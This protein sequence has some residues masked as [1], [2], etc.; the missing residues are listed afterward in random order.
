[1]SK[2]EKCECDVAAAYLAEKDQSLCKFWG[3]DCGTGMR[4]EI[5]LL[6]YI[7]MQD[8]YKDHKTY[9]VALAPG[10]SGT[11]PNI[12]SEVE[13]TFYACDSYVVNMK[14]LLNGVVVF[15]NFLLRPLMLKEDWEFAHLDDE[16]DKQGLQAGTLK[17]RLNDYT[18]PPA[19]T[20]CIKGMNIHSVFKVHSTDP[21]RMSPLLPG[22]VA[23]FK[24]SFHAKPGDMVTVYIYLKD[25]DTVH[26]SY[27]ESVAETICGGADRREAK[28]NP[29][30]E[31]MCG[32]TVPFGEAPQGLSNL[33]AH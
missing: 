9:R 26:S 18:L 32:P 3:L 13:R 5:D 12:D 6:D 14:L 4:A 23:P 30:Q 24:E 17:C 33:S 2:G 8:M 28:K 10:I 11:Q 1:M 15:S 31:G 16:T 27:V 21:E 7:E 22:E 25:C 20:K 19:V 29:A